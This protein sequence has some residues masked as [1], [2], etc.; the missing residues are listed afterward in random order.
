LGEKLWARDKEISEARR[1][2]VSNKVHLVEY[3]KAT[4]YLQDA[5]KRV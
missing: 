2:N 4:M 5:I 1:K 3:M